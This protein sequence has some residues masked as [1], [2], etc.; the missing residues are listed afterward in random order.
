MI[1]QYR[2]KRTIWRKL[3]EIGIHKEINNDIK[4]KKNEK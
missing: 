1:E 4:Q 2:K 3:I